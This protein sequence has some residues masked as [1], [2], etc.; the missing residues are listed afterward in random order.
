[1]FAFGVNTPCEYNLA[2]SISLLAVRENYHLIDTRVNISQLMYTRHKNKSTSSLC[3]AF[4]RT[5]F[6]KRGVFQTLNGIDGQN[7]DTCRSIPGCARHARCT[8]S[9]PRYPYTF[10]HMRMHMHM[11]RRANA[12]ARRTGSRPPCCMRAALAW[13]QADGW[14]VAGQG[15]LFLSLP[16]LYFIPGIYLLRNS[17]IVYLVGRARAR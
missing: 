13:Q 11:H 4:K 1:M 17:C 9:I 8:V 12:R 5:V 2:A 10:T 7:I 15:R 16:Q 14:P 3:R 6:G